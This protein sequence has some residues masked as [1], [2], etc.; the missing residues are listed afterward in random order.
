[1]SPEERARRCVDE[2]GTHGDFCQLEPFIVQAIQA[3][4][5]AERE[6][7]AAICDELAAKYGQEAEECAAAIRV[8]GSK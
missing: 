6:A 2:I 4:V 5:E 3:A 8:R 1:M 7:C